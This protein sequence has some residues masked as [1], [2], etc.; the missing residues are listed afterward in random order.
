SSHLGGLRDP[1]VYQSAVAAFRKELDVCLEAAI[2]GVRRVGEEIE[3]R[4]QVPGEAEVIERFEY[5][6][7][8]AGR[9]PNI[10]NLGLENTSAEL[11]ERG[12]PAYDS[13]TLRIGNTPLF[14][15]GDV[16]GVL[17]L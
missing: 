3:V 9:V 7:L 11:D 12:R 13:A 8:A 2:L 10:E 4:Y 14:I 5:L 17:P 15:A 16:T 1:L 6:L